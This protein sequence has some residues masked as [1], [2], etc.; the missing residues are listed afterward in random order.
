MNE[1]TRVLYQNKSDQRQ[2]RL[3]QMLSFELLRSGALTYLNQ[4][5]LEIFLPLRSLLKERVSFFLY[6]KYALPENA[7][8]NVTVVESKLVK[9]ISPS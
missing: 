6:D 4:W 8:E 9:V 7:D 1:E 2:E 5:G 3:E